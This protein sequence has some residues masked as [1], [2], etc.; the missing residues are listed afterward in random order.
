TWEAAGGK[1]DR[2]GESFF[3]LPDLRDTALISWHCHSMTV[4]CRMPARA[5]TAVARPS[6]RAK[7]LRG[8]RKTRNSRSFCIIE[9]RGGSVDYLFQPSGRYFLVL[10]IMSS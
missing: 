2:V 3:P 5:S 4:A 1:T 7:K 8:I 10:S 9:Q 6:Y